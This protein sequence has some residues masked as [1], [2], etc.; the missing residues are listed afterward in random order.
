MSCPWHDAATHGSGT[1]RTARAEVQGLTEH[2]PNPLQGRSAWWYNPRV[3]H[4]SGSGN[5]VCQTHRGVLFL[6]ELPEFRRELLELLRQPLEDKV[7]TISRAQGSLTFPANFMLVGA[8]NPCPCGY[9]GDP[10]RE[11]S[12][13]P[14]LVSRYQKRISGPFLDR[15][16]IFVD[17][18]R[19]DYEKLSDDRLGEP[20]ARVQ[21]RVEKTRRRQ[22]ERFG[23]GRVTCNAEMTPGEVREYCRVEGSAQGL[24]KAAM[25]QLSLSARAFHRILKL[26]RTIADLEGNGSIEAPHLAEAIQ[27]RPRS[28]V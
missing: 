13:S 11:C 19:V 20:S 27:Y 7:I 15:V 12:C 1:R 14:G 3:R 17:V 6:D 28:L 8:M 18:P 16:D 5:C 10:T 25:Q 2:L 4:G 9:Y 24:L 21:E 22:R 23:A 26:A